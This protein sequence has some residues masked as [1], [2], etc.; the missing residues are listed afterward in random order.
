MHSSF[1]DPGTFD[2]WALLPAGKDGDRG[3]LATVHDLWPGIDSGREKPVFDHPKTVAEYLAFERVSDAKHEYVDGFIYAMAGASDDHVSIVGNLTAAF[4][5]QLRGKKC[6]SYSSDMAL[7][8]DAEKAD[9]SKGTFYY[10]DV[11]VTCSDRDR[12]SRIKKDPVLVVEVLSEGTEKLDQTEKLETYRAT[13]TLQQYW[14]VHQG[15]KRIVVH[16]RGP[17]GWTS[18]EMTSGRLRVELPGGALEVSVDEIYEEVLGLEH[19][20]DS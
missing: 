10:P 14:L 11:V 1:L 3:G 8:K 12:G 9:F 4:V 7:A 19:R 16:S 15:Q 18:E 6:R 2:Q 20:S 13:P 17:G 5:V